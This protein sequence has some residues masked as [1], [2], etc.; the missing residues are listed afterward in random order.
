MRN[1]RPQR[2]RNREFWQ[3]NCD[4]FG[5]NSLNAD[6]EILTLALDVM[7]AF[8]PPKG[9][10]CLALNNRQLLDGLLEV[11]KVKN[12]LKI[13]VVRLL[14]KYA[15][16]TA[17]NFIKSLSD[18]G[19][20]N[21]AI[22]IIVKFM[23]AESLADL[24]SKLPELANNEGWKDLVKTMETLESL[25]YS[26]YIEFKPSV[27][28]GFDYYDGLV[29]EVF[30]KHPDNNRALFGGGRYNSLSELFGGQKFSAVGIAPGDE[31][32]KLFLESWGLL[33]KIKA[34]APEVSYVPLLSSE[35]VLATQ[36]LAQSL[37]S[38]GMA[39]ELGL[40]VTKIG[41]ALEY[42]NKKEMAQVIIFGEDEAQGK[43]YKI[44]DM[45]T[46]SE[47]KIKLNK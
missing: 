43:F 29:F 34:T 12:D 14:D 4:I 13:K 47:R 8:N 19:L 45:K 15:K 7:L 11:I 9:S 32:T 42:A 20:K 46:S 21:A 36:K 44:K 28:R 39:I 5:S 24:K 2:G 26:D 41:K 10:F 3:L 37:R 18:L 1:E 40:E 6:L 16:M 17:D 31:T 38:Q 22:D 33:D 25:G 35:L 27:I 30:D 23:T